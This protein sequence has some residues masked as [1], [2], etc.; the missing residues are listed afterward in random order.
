MPEI[1]SSTNNRVKRVKRLLN[2]RR[3]RLR[4]GQFVVEGTRWIDEITRAGVPPIFWFATENWLEANPTLSIRLTAESEPPITIEPSLLKELAD[5]STPSGVLAV[6]Q[7]P[8]L[9]WPEDPT[10]LLLLDQIRDPGNLGTLMRSALA[11]GV[12]G[13]ILSP[14][15]VEPF[16]PKVVRSS[17]GAVLRLPVRHASWADKGKMAELLGEC[18]IY[19][20]DAAGEKAYTDVDWTQSA[21]I[22]IGG[23]AAGADEVAKSIVHEMISI[24]MAQ[25][26]ESLNAGVAGSVILFEALRQK[27][28]VPKIIEHADIEM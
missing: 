8:D 15:C 7:R 25:A 21:A 12:E 16:N 2:D 28:L 14:G 22:M 4:E 23:E 3:F 1:T 27:S 9:Q 5:T 20:A 24:P 13:L 10:F 17:M 11:A 19:L 26:T 6:L 18:Q